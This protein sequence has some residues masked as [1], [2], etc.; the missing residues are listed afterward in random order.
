MLKCLGNRK[1][2]GVIEYSIVMVVVIIGVI[3]MGPYVIRSWNANLQGY[4]DS[5]RDSY[6]DPLKEPGKI[7]GFPGDGC[8]CR[9]T[10]PCGVAD[11]TTPCCGEFGCN[12]NETASIYSCFPAKCTDHSGIPDDK[13]KC[14]PS[15]GCCTSWEFMETPETCAKA[16]GSEGLECGEGEACQEQTCTDIL[17]NPTVDNQCKPHGD[18]NFICLPKYTSYEG[19]SYGDETHIC[20]NTEA[21]LTST[22]RWSFINYDDKCDAVEHAGKKCVAKCADGFEP[23]NE[24]DICQDNCARETTAKMRWDSGCGE[25][26]WKEG[27]VDVSLFKY[28]DSAGNYVALPT[29]YKLKKSDIK[30]MTWDLKVYAPRSNND[31]HYTDIPVHMGGDSYWVFHHDQNYELTADIDLYPN[32]KTSNCGCNPEYIRRL[33][34]DQHDKGRNNHTQNMTA[35]AIFDGSD[36]VDFIQVWSCAPD[37]SGTVGFPDDGHLGSLTNI[38]VTVELKECIASSGWYQQ[39]KGVGYSL[40]GPNSCFDLCKDKGLV[41]GVSPDG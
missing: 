28:K 23:S 36:N 16:C 13:V 9:W 8:F 10:N 39:D 6:E 11:D 27:V 20:E 15:S 34:L 1:G 22:T 38:T 40:G 5:V 26:R 41:P 7:P 3:I 25:T 14:E 35:K 4:A 18:C 30:S 32:M 21:D 33:V 29:G 24:G 12:A 17:G 31:F 19:P 2:Q 37:K